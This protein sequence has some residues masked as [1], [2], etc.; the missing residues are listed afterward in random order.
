ML[1]IAIV[2]LM[3]TESAMLNALSIGADDGKKTANGT[4]KGE[5]MELLPC[6]C[7]G[8]AEFVKLYE[9]K[10]YGGFVVCRKCGCET[11]AYTSKQ[12]AVKAWNK[13]QK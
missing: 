13:M 9:T 3:D 1:F 12:N 6:K 11:K 7:G 10:W 2:P 8:K 4:E 5:P